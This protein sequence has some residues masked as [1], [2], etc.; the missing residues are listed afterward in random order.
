MPAQE[1]LLHLSPVVQALPS[2]HDAVL[3]V[4]VQPPVP[5]HTSSVH[6]LLSSQLYGVPLQTWFLQRS[7]RVQG[8]PSSQEPVPLQVLAGCVA[9]KLEKCRVGARTWV[10][11][12]LSVTRV[13]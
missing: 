12:T 13:S 7:L 11:S 9:T 8:F 2:V 6:A 10:A 5:L 1:P 4:W 3:L